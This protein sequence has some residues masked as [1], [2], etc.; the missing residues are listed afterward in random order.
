MV[1]AGMSQRQAAKV[2][3]ISQSTVR[4][5][6][7]RNYSISEQKLLTKAERRAE[8]EAE[9]GAKQL[10]LP[11][12]RYGVIYADSPWRFEPYSRE[13]GMDR[14]PENHYPTS[15]TTV[16]AER[17]VAGIAADDCVLFLWATARMLREAMRVMEAWGFEYR[18][19]SAVAS[20]DA[21]PGGAPQGAGIY[22]SLVLYCSMSAAVSATQ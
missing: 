13:T 18:S 14:S 6:L 16:I 19:G 2:L 11:T 7:S 9:L 8:R 15:T 21:H 5:D 20:I 1:D 17:N 4:N 3:G 10:A 22:G 12:K